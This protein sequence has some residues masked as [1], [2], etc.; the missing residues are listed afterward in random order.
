MTTTEQMED[1]MP[2]HEDAP[3]G[4]T[5]EISFDGNRPILSLR[6][7]HVTHPDYINALP[8]I[9]RQRMSYDKRTAT[10]IT[11]TIIT[12]RTGL[13]SKSRPTA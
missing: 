7:H 2:E 12:I 1:S 3:D 6:G 11:T 9:E 5:G 8:Y 13:T 4:A 10:I